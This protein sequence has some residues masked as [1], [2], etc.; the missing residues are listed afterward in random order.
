MLGA[1][2]PTGFSP[3]L[4]AE[5]PPDGAILRA[6]RMDACQ[7][8]TR[9]WQNPKAPQAVRHQQVLIIQPRRVQRLGGRLYTIRDSSY[10]LLMGHAGSVSFTFLADTHGC[11]DFLGR[12]LNRR[13]RGGNLPRRRKDPR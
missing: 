1:V 3:D 13:L 11:R 6:K 9:E 12:C 10:S 8:T 4:M 5:F 7:T 2:V